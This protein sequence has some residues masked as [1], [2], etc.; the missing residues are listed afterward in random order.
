MHSKKQS[1]VKS[2]VRKRKVLK[3]EAQKIDYSNY[4][5]VLKCVHEPIEERP[6]EF[7]ISNKLIYS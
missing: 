2:S 4:H 3:G 6:H 1:G 7:E 5:S